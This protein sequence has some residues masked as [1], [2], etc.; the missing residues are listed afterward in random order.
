MGPLE[1]EV[2]KKILWL[3]DNTSFVEQDKDA[4]KAH[5]RGTHWF[6]IFG[7]MRQYSKV[8]FLS[9]LFFSF[10]LTA[11]LLLNLH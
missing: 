5:P 10:F 1:E 8:R 9:S 3:V 6:S 2:A 11:N 7:H 4:Q